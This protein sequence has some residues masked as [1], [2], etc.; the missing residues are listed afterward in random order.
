MTQN[1]EQRVDDAL[2]RIFVEAYTLASPYMNAQ[3]QWLSLAHECLAND[4]LAERFPNMGGVR[5]MAVL[6]TIAQ[7]RNS[8]RVPVD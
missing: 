4:A 2:R 1:R 5:L 3:G 8:G 7:V 6:A